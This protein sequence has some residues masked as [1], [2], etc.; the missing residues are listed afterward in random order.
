MNFLYKRFISWIPYINSF[1]DKSASGTNLILD[2]SDR[3]IG[4]AISIYI[5]FSLDQ[6][7]ADQTSSAGIVVGAVRGRGFAA[8][9]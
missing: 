7:P 9:I 3:K 4:D 2:R 1:S 8:S 6:V 5:P